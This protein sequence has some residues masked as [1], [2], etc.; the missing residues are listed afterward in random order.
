VYNANSGNVGI[1]TTA[2]THKLHIVSNATSAL[3]I[4]ALN[5]GTDAIS[6]GG[7]GKFTIDA[8]NIFGGRFIVNEDGKV[9]VGTAAPTALLDVAGTLNA[10]AWKTQS[11]TPNGYANMG[12]I[13][14]QWGTV[15]YKENN[16]KTVTYPV[17]FTEVF[18]VTLTLDNNNVGSN[19]GNIPP[20]LSRVENSYFGL[21]GTQVFSGGLNKV[22]WMAVGR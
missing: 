4:D 17:A 14:M 16:N 2:P 22:R 18:S 8:P 10:N 6:I 15:D 20:K 13:L 7:A 21:A 19:G 5:P 12:G 11:A 3:R 9:G 1:G